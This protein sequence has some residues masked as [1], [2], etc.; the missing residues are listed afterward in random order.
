[1][2]KEIACIDIGTT[3]VSLLI[4]RPSREGL[5]IAEIITVPSRGMRKGEIID[6]TLVADSIK[7]AFKEVKFRGGLSKTGLSVVA[8]LSGPQVT[9]TESYGAAGI[10]GRKITEKDI[11]NAIDSAGSLY[12]PLDREVLHIIPVEY[13]VDGQQGIRN[14][15]GMRGYRL[16]VKVQ[17]ITTGL[18]YLDNL[19][20]VFH[21]AGLR[22]DEFVYRPIATARSVLK[23][24]EMEEGVVLIDAGG[25][26]SEVAVFKERKLLYAVSVPVGGNHIT[27]DIAIGL[28]VP[29]SEAERIKIKYG[30]ALVRRSDEQ[31]EIDHSRSKRYCFLRNLDEIVFARCEEMASLIK[32]EISKVVS[33]GISLSGAVLTGGTS[34]LR[35]L[36]NLFESYLEMPVR[37][38]LP[39]GQRLSSPALSVV[40][41]LFEILSDGDSRVSRSPF[42]K[43]TFIEKLKALARVFHKK[44]VS[45]V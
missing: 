23:E 24:E 10:G 27:N 18:L 5:H 2:A 40:A 32:K 17:I 44:E 34:L 43:E 7:R 33:Q 11:Q 12:I 26:T 19:R 38:G 31:I 6:M 20:E 35:G 4:A 21:A 8:G 16:E 41:G 15:L 30:S 28:K 3:K 1:M 29:V 25:G 36:D 22:I 37:T 14:P 42:S 9:I 13:S 45:Y 39:S